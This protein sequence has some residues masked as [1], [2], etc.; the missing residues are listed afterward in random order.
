MICL[1]PEDENEKTCDNIAGEIEKNFEDEEE[2]RKKTC[3][4]IIFFYLAHLGG[5]IHCKSVEMV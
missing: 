3:G 5:L 1:H 4:F 2:D